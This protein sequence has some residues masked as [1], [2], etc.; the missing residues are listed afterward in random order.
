MSKRGFTL[1]EIMIPSLI[2]GFVLFGTSTYLILSTRLSS[3]SYSKAITTNYSSAIFSEI[4][5]TVREG[6][7]ITIDSSDNTTFQVNYKDVTL[8]STVFTYDNSDSTLYKDGSRLNPLTV[9]VVC[10]FTSLSSHPNTAVRSRVDVLQMVDN[11]LINSGFLIS[12][13]LCRNNL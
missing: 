9:K 1:I 8:S 13:V 5:D 6:S 11:E 7:S 4:V 10:D 3:E 12:R 2:G